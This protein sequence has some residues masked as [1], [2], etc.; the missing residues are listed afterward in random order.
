LVDIIDLLSAGVDC[1]IVSEGAELTVNLR[2]RFGIVAE[3][4]EVPYVPLNDIEPVIVAGTAEGLVVNTSVT[5]GLESPE[6][7]FPGKS[8][9]LFAIWI[10]LFPDFADVHKPCCN[11]GRVILTSSRS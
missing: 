6:V 2:G 8:T 10:L 3:D 5:T 1:E 11:A 9:W 7:I 4:P